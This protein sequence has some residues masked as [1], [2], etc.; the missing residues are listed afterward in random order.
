MT[1][2]NTRTSDH[3][4]DPLFLERWSPRAFLQD[5]IS[6]AD[7]MRMFE[8]ARWA[9]SSYNSQP[10]RFLW[11]RR[12][13]A[14]WDKFLGLLNPFNQSWAKDASALVVLVSN[15]LMRP[16]GAEKDVPSHSHSLD[17]GAASGNFALQ[18]TRMGWNVHGMVGF[19]MDRAFA[20]LNVPK[21]YRVEAAYA[22]GKRGD[23]ATLPEAL[24]AREAPSPRKPVAE[25]A[26]E[27]GFTA[28]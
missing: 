15:S 21:G 13:T 6:E 25:I 9:A 12:G 20:E 11:A 28:S 8:A 18:A 7:L 3:D 26:M 1:T 10:W 5:E 14:H 17:A 4:I 24:Q 27:G 22:V 19:D 2:A 16:P 23:K